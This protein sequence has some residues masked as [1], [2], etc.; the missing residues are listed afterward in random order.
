MLAEPA[1]AEAAV[2]E[3]AAEEAVEDAATVLEAEPPQLVNASAETAEAAI[4]ALRK[5]RREIMF[6]VFIAVAPFPE[7]AAQKIKPAPPAE[8]VK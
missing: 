2:L 1:A 6:M 8:R 7:R 5:L 3:A 4:A